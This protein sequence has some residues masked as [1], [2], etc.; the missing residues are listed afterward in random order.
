LDLCCRLVSSCCA[1]VA[2]LTHARA[3]R[4]ERERASEHEHRLMRQ[5]V[6]LREAN[7]QRAGAAAAASS[8]LAAVLTEMYLCNVCSC[9]ETLRRNGRGQ[10]AARRSRPRCGR[11]GAPSSSPRRR[12]SSPQR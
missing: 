3:N 5:E 11:L 4:Q 2:W 9:H 10:S 12:R 8:F 7:A 6:I 1:A